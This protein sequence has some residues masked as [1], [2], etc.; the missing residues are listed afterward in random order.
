[1]CKGN[2]LFEQQT[3][4]LG[5]LQEWGHFERILSPGLHVINPISQSIIEVSQQT[6]VIEYSQL[7]MSKDNVQT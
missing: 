7:A 2:L 3:S 6:K 5:L 4:S 1:M